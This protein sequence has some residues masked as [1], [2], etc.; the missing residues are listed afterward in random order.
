MAKLP[1]RNIAPKDVSKKL[2][3]VHKSSVEDG[4]TGVDAGVDYKPRD[5][6]GQAFV[7]AHKTE[8]HADR[9]GND[10][11]F[12]GAD[13]L[14]YVLDLATNKLMGRGPA[15]SKKV[16]ESKEEED[17]QCNHSPKGKSCPVHGIAE[18]SGMKMIK[19][20]GKGLQEVLTKKT[21]TETVIKDFVHSDAP[22]FKGKSTKERIR[23][24]LGAKYGMMR[25]EDVSEA[26]DQDDTDEEVS[27]VTTELR[28][29]C[30]KSEELLKKMP[31]NMHI[32]PWVQAKVAMAKA[33]IGNIHDYIMYKD[34]KEDLAEPMLEDGKTKKSKSKKK[35]E[36]EEAAAGDT[37]M[38]IT[39]GAYPSG[40]VGDT[41]RV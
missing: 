34:M 26:K 3:G 27:M 41:G 15:E 31:A 20:K 14:K 9:A 33:S 5:E 24:A 13:S 23:M 21:P 19:E 30:A 25:K 1:L 7:K 36:K 16:Y 12:T 37:Q 17:A 4:S 29:I 40:N 32:E 11:G 39:S 10:K 18:C 22:Q 28:A 38:D 2:E 35:M 8:K 6:M